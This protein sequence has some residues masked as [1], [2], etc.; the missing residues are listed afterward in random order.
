MR[1]LPFFYTSISGI[2]S[3]V[4]VLDES[5]SECPARDRA[6]LLSPGKGPGPR[7]SIPTYARVFVFVCIRAGN[8]WLCCHHSGS[9]CAVSVPAGWQRGESLSAAHPG[10]E[11]LPAHLLSHHLGP[12]VCGCPA[13]DPLGSS[14][15][16]R[17]SA[18]SSLLVNRENNKQQT[19]LCLL[20]STTV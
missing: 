10:G 6:S 1:Y 7:A 19:L 11:G 9:Y 2:W 17:T 15:C 5:V 8:T 20:Y 13:S 12:R 16:R 14:P 4:Y 18:L 3:I